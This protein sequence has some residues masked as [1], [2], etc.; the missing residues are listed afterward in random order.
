MVGFAGSWWASGF[1][2]FFVVRAWDLLK[3]GLVVLGR[4]AS[5]LGMYGFRNLEVQGFGV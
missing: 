2:V 1:Q 5:G 3:L 4:R